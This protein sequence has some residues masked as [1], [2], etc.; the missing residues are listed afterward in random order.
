MGDLNTVSL[1]VFVQLADVIFEKALENASMPARSSGLFKVSPIPGNSGESRQYTEIDQE[2][3][4]DFKGEGA[5]A[6]QANVQQG[7]SKTLTAFRVAKDLPITYE[8]RTRNKYPQVIGRLTSLANL[9]VRRMELDLSHRIGFGTATSMTDKDGR[10]IDLSLGN[11]LS[12]FNTAHTLNGSSTTFRNRLAGN[13][14]I[15]RGALEGLER[16]AVEQTYNHLGE[17][18]PVMPG[19][20]DILWT[21]ADPTDVNAAREYLQSTA[22]VEGSNSGVINV[23]KGKYR[24]VILPLVP[25]T[26]VGAI[27]TSKRHYWGIA[28][29]EMST[30]HLDVWEEPHLKSPKADQGEDFSTDDWSFGVRAGYGICVLNGSWIRFSSGDGAA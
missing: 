25:T 24:H 26:A 16:L 30:A 9:G 27:D 17:L 11:S 23:Y 4:A 7:F 3:Y 29:S 19:L 15:S 14:V 2:L 12:L 1:P 18:V 20:Y 13:P 8:M 22:E 21:T 6:G 5:Q 10:S 28:S